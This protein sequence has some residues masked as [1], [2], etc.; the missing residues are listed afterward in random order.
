MTEARADAQLTTQQIDFLLRGVHGS[1]VGKD[2]KGFAHLEA[3]DV[4]RHLIR[5]FGFGGYDTEQ[6]EMTLV[7]QVEHPPSGGR[8]KSRWTVIYRATV[9][10][11]VK[12]G[13]V[14]LGHWHGTASGDATNQPSLA[15]AHDLA[16]KTADSQAFKR[17]AVNLGDQ[18]GMSLYNGGSLEPV[19]LRS[20]AYVSE[21]V[22]E[23]EDSPV[24]P[25][26]VLSAPHAVPDSDLSAPL[27]DFVAEARAAETADVVRGIW[28]EARD[29]GETEERLGWI[30][31]IGRALAAEPTEKPADVEPVD[32]EVVDDTATA[33]E[34]EAEAAERELRAWA[35][36]AQ[37]PDIA[38]D[39]EGAKGAPLAQATAQQIRAFHRELAGPM[40][41]AS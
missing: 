25:E 35:D 41:A 18:F 8:G 13:G 7:S 11:R 15:D 21:P 33:D 31:S 40:A 23:S 4:R 38:A 22:A 30:A 29:A 5:V 19:V 14:E 28:Q 37:L 12:V 34:D 1:R 20:L 36:E 17:A 16:M 24:R 3:W 39:F 27:R 9:V 2:G 32:A 6:Q 26:P 10:L